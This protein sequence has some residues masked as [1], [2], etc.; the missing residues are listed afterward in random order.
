VLTQLGD[1]G[2]RATRGQGVKTHDQDTVA[3]VGVAA[4]G[5]GL[6]DQGV[7]FV[8]RVGVVGVDAD[9]AG[10]GCGGIGRG[11]ADG[12]G[13]QFGLNV[14]DLLAGRRRAVSAQVMGK[15][16]PDCRIRRQRTAPP[17]P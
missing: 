2:G 1:S 12:V 10:Q 4:A 15:A 17:V 7:G 9:G 13:D 3:G 8:A 16:S 6:A 5:E 11:D 14:Q